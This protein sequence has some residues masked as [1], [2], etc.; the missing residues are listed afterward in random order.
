MGTWVL[1]LVNISIRIGKV[2]EAFREGIAL[3]TVVPLVDVSFVLVSLVF[4]SPKATTLSTRFCVAARA[5]G[6]TAKVL[7]SVAGV[8]LLVVSTQVG[9]TTKSQVIAA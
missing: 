3:I 5:P 8:L 7:D 4:S 6:V 2:S 1:R 9:E